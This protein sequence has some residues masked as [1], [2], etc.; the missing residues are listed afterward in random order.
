VQARQVFLIRPGWELAAGRCSRGLG[1]VS[2]RSPRAARPPPRSAA[3]SP[4]SSA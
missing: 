4:P 3:T 2:D 1:G